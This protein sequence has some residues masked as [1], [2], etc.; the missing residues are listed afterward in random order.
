MCYILVAKTLHFYLLFKVNGDTGIKLQYTHCRL[1]SLEEIN[2]NIT[3][4]DK[5]VPE[6]LTEVVAIDLILEICR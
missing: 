5:V 3:I 6:C 2:S 4:P 1:I